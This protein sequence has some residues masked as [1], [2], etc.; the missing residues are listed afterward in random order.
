MV[1]SVRSSSRS[2]ETQASC[3]RN[4]VRLLFLTEALRESHGRRIQERFIVVISSKRGQTRAKDVK[5]S[6]PGDFFYC[7]ALLIVES[8]FDS[9]GVRAISRGLSPDAPGRYPRL[10]IEN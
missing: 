5:K 9:E 8:Q 3:G 6:N 2:S 7:S 4:G 10:R 1:S